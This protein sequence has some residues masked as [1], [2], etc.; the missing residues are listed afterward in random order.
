MSKITKVLSNFS[1]IRKQLT[2]YHFKWLML[3][4]FC[5]VMYVQGPLIHSLFPLRVRYHW[6]TRIE[7]FW[8]N[9]AKLP[10]AL[11]T[12]ICK[13]EEEPDWTHLYHLAASITVYCIHK[14]INDD[15]GVLDHY[16][17][18]REPIFWT[19]RVFILWILAKKSYL[20][21]LYLHH[22]ET[23]LKTQPYGYNNMMT[24]RERGT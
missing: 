24:L 17:R 20:A 8:W 21:T 19:T 1:L 22:R 5:Q 15:F 4:L 14:L 18:K 23:I 11:E 6:L 7:E 3:L 12:C 13:N 9:F 2:C 10:R 16:S